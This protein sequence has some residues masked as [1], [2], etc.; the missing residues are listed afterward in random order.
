M[1]ETD[2]SVNLAPLSRLHKDKM[3]FVKRLNEML[4]IQ[5]LKPALN[6]QSDSLRAKVFM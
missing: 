2:V 6:I 1:I 4:C 5:D 3:R